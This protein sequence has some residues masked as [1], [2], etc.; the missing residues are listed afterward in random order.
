MYKMN[1]QC[2]FGQYSV[3][4]FTLAVVAVKTAYATPT[5]VQLLGIVSAL[6]YICFNNRL[7]Y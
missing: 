2:L 7:R 3:V 4:W 6:L 5:S 1:I